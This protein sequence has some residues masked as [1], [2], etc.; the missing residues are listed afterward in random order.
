MLDHASV[1]T[2]IAAGGDNSFY[3][4]SDGSVWAMGRNDSGQLGNGALNG[5]NDPQQVF[6]SDVIAIAVGG[7]DTLDTHTLFLK[8]DGSLWAVGANDF[9]QLGDGTTNNTATPKE[10]ISSGITAIAAGGWQSFFLKS[11][12]SLWA[13]GR[14]DYGQLGDGTTNN[15]SNPKLILPGGVTAIAAGNFHTLVLKT[16]GSLWAMGANNDGQ[17]GHGTPPFATNT[18]MQI[19]ASNV[20]AIATGANH[21]LILKSDSSLWAAGYNEFGQL[22]TGLSG[23]TANVY[24]LVRIW[25]SGVTAIAAGGNHS[26]FIRSDGSLWGM[27]YDWDGELGDGGLSMQSV[28]KELAPGPVIAIT[29]GSS[30]SLFLK[31]D[32]T[33]WAMGWDFYGQ[34]GDRFVGPGMFAEQVFPRLQPILIGSVSETNLQFKATCSFGGTFRLLTATNLAQPR[35]QWT[36]VYTQTLGFSGPDNFN[37]ILTNAANTFA[38]PQYFI[39]QSQ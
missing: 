11:D 23:T 26:L 9:G 10:I 4:K 29:A 16:N 19:L 32:N 17:L 31:G 25:S 22:G 37:T 6:S 12:G 27:G 34:L 1:V 24:G 21:S 15:S 20:T 39:L 28:S 35:D 33:V 13:M 8:S 7:G 3:L 30:H 38:D 5:T 14:N 36:A 2:N 18:P